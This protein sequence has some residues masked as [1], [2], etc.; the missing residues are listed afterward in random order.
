MRYLL[1]F[2]NCCICSAQSVSLG[3]VGGVRGTDDITNAATS[4]SKRY[5]AGPTFEVGLPLG[6]AVEADALYSREGYSVGYG[7]FAYTSVQQERAN[8]WT[9]PL[10]LKYRIRLPLIKPFVEVGYSPRTINGTIH[11]DNTST[12]FTTGQST[13]GS[14]SSATNWKISQGLVAGGGVQFN[15]GKL[16][17]SPEVRYTRW[18]NMAIYGY[19]SDGPSYGSAQ[20][21]VDIMVEIAWRVRG[22]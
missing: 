3:V 17:L 20:N 4:E 19:F 9:F 18:N 1:I 11:S 14:T 2:I 22:E 16:Q 21:Q 8:A 10:L 6:F 7:N 12:D 13:S 15:T 5:I